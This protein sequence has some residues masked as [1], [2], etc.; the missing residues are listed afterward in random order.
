MRSLERADLRLPVESDFVALPR[1]AGRDESK[2]LEVEIR[3][4]GI[5]FG[6]LLLG[7]QPAP[8]AHGALEVVEPISLT[9]RLSQTLLDAAPRAVSSARRDGS[10]AANAGHRSLG[11]T[12]PQRSRF[13]GDP[14]ALPVPSHTGGVLDRATQRLPSMSRARHPGKVEAGPQPPELATHLSAH[15]S[16]Q[17]HGGVLRQFGLHLVDLAA[18]VRAPVR[19]VDGASGVPF[20]EVRPQTGLVSLLAL[21]STPRKNCRARTGILLEAGESGELRGEPPRTPDRPRHGPD[22]TFVGRAPLQAQSGLEPAREGIVQERRDGG[23]DRGAS[24][25]GLEST[26]RV[27]SP[28]G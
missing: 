23:D 8:P 18:P 6:F 7:H 1:V 9:H 4:E 27:S 22:P 20:K 28:S 17:H 14:R 11:I 15:E 24:G 5:R 12:R 16:H 19:E 3:G 25:S 13:R 21:V 10:L 2:A 26:R